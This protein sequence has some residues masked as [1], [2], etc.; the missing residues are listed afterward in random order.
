M[1]NILVTAMMVMATLLVGASAAP[2]AAATAVEYAECHGQ[3]SLNCTYEECKG[4]GEQQVCKEHRCT[5]WFRD[6]FPYAC[7]VG[8]VY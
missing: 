3:T 8:T 2:T 7:V 6:L 1:R 5:F 4:E